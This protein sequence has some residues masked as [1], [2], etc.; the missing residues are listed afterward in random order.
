MMRVAVT[1][2]C[3]LVNCRV[4]VFRVEMRHGQLELS[5]WTVCV[6]KLE[7]LLVSCEDNGFESF[8]TRDEELN[9]RW[10]RLTELVEHREVCTLAVCSN[11]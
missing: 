1:F 5:R 9:E 10:T 4:Q 7:E 3:T 8:V 2:R 6:H 11:E